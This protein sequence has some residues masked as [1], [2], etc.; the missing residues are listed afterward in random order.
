MCSL[1]YILTSQTSISTLV[2]YMGPLEQVFR[3]IT[4]I[5]GIHT[6]RVSLVQAMHIDMMLS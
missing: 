2:K 5:L 3:Q 6:H 1:A 4:F